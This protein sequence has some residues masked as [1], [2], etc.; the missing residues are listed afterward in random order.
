[1]Y[2]RCAGKADV[3]QIESQHGFDHVNTHDTCNM[4]YQSGGRGQGSSHC[5]LQNA[6]LI[7]SNLTINYF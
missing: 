2:N 4:L 7:V 1:M 5:K 3:T 6:I